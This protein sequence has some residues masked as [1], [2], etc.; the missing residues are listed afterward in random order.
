MPKMSED[1]KKVLREIIKQLDERVPP[2]EVKNQFKQILETTTPEEI[3]QIEQELVQEGMPREELHRLCDVHL[4]LFADQ[5]K[6]QTLNLPNEHPLSILME[7]HKLLTHDSE[8]LGIIT[9]L[10]DEAC[11]YVYINDALTEL[12][13]IVTD[14]LKAEKHY[15]REENVLFPMI[16]KHGI[17]EPPAIMWMEHNQ[18]RENK[19]ELQKL[20]QNWNSTKYQEFKTRLDQISTALCSLLPNHFFKEN[21]ILFPAANQVITED[22]WTEIRNEFDEIGYW[23]YTPPHMQAKIQIEAKKTPTTEKELVF[24]NGQLSKEEIAGILD[25]LPIDVTFVDKN[26]QVKYFSKGEK[27]IFVRTRAVLGRKVQMCHPQ[28]SIS[29]VN[30]IV[31]AFKTGKKDNAE[32]W[33]NLNERLIH[34]RYFAVRDKNRDYLGTMEVTQDLTDIKRIQGEKRL[35]DAEG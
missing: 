23:S 35:L 11:D 26:D 20:A 29:V 24:E 25:N 14:L 17:T 28:K 10:V 13:Q 4:A 19:K 1:K 16:E 2:Q 6:N 5:T 30:Q 22:E 8:R 32:F 15:Q 18:I 27:R 31:E 3:A 12:Q 21:T 9:N 33:I 7:E 34:I